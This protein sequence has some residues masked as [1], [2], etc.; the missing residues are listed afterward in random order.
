MMPSATFG[1]C[2]VFQTREMLRAALILCAT[3]SAARAATYAVTNL[4]SNGGAPTTAY[5]INSVGQIVGSSSNPSA[6][7]PINPINGNAINSAGRVVGDSLLADNTTDHAFIYTAGVMK[8][9]NTMIGTASINWILN[10]AYDIDD[11][12]RIVGYGMFD[13]DGAG[14]APAVQRG[15]L[16]S[17]PEPSATLL[18][19]CG[20]PLLSRR[21]L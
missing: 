7:R 17:L 1:G 15:F 18:L 20:L 10:A 19:F 14:P 11:T 6:P 21:R 12:G 5:G 8:D 3:V 4:G 16:L 2:S 9:L 13:P